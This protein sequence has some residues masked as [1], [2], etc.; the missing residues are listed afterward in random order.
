MILFFARF[1]VASALERGVGVVDTRRG[2]LLRVVESS[3][4]NLVE[5]EG[6]RNALSFV[7]LGN[8]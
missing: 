8:K 6:E 5:G 3:R 4:V 1:R 2:D 7:M